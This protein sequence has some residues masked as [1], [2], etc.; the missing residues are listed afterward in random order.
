MMTFVLTGTTSL[1]F[2]KHK[3][4]HLH[5]DSSASDKTKQ[6]EENKKSERNASDYQNSSILSEFLKGTGFENDLSLGPLTAPI[7][8]SI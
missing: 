8:L 5:G 7:P 3:T 2:I 6:I 1:F 4:G